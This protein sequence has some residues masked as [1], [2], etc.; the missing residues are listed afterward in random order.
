MAPEIIKKKLVISEIYSI[1]RRY[2]IYLCEIKVSKSANIKFEFYLFSS[3]IKWYYLDVNY[4][5]NSLSL[6]GSFLT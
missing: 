4:F 2:Y 1:L 5:G 6:L 3:A